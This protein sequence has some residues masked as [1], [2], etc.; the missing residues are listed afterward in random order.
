VYHDILPEHV[1]ENTTNRN[2]RQH[3]ACRTLPS[4]GAD[5][6]ARFRLRNETARRRADSGPFI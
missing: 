5:L 4:V 6:D 3:M 1:A 2:M